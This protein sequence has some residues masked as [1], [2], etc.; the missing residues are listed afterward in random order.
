[1]LLAVTTGYLV[2]GTLNPVGILNRALIYGP[3]LALLWVALL[4][5]IEIFYSR[6][7]WCRYVCP[8]GLT[9][10]VIGSASPIK[11]IHNISG[12]AHEGDCRKVCMVPHVLDCIKRNR[13]PT[14]ETELGADCTRCG[15]C[16][17]TCPTKS[18]R[19]E[20]RGLSKLI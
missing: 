12:C 20:I 4:L 17:E 14:V 11:V 8:I 15:M 2:F 5:A 16:V 6:R 10:G 1:M 3:G 13:A 18:L 7:L 9:Y 19:F